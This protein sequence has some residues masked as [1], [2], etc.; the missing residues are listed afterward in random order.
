MKG[1]LRSG[2]LISHDSRCSGEAEE[3]GRQWVDLHR[4]RCRARYRKCQQHEVLRSAA[5]HCADR[6]CCESPAPDASLTLRACAGVEYT[7]KSRLLD[8]SQLMQNTQPVPGVIGVASIKQGSRE[9]HAV[10]HSI[11]K[12]ASQLSFATLRIVITAD[13]VRNI[14]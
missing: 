3:H 5:K 10:P 14:Y 13:I 7:R 11:Q 2:L 4:V 6:C 12:L 8:P 1:H 9:W